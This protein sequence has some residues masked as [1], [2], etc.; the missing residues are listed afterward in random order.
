[1][2]FSSCRF[3][4]TCVFIIHKQARISF[5]SSSFLGSHKF[6][7]TINFQL[8]G[9]KV[10]VSKSRKSSVTSTLS[11]RST[12]L[13]KSEDVKSHILQQ[14]QKRKEDYKKMKKQRKRAGNASTSMGKFI[15][16]LHIYITYLIFLGSWVQFFKLFSCGNT[17]TFVHVHF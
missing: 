13:K 2:I 9:V 14:N 8:K 7:L 10:A 12:R 16:Y 1:M 4:Y 15:L 11:K 3:S 17:Y 6:I 5:K